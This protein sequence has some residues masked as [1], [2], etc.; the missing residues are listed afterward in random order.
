MAD[1]FALIA[2]PRSPFSLRFP[3]DERPFKNGE[4]AVTGRRGCVAVPYLF[5][6]N[7]HRCVVK[8]YR[9]VAKTDLIC[10]RFN[11]RL[12]INAHTAIEYP[13]YLQFDKSLLLKACESQLISTRQVIHVL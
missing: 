8:A 12:L 3:S 2:A 1:T 7:A 11:E 9:C 5:V 4:F 13:P 10:K 6:V